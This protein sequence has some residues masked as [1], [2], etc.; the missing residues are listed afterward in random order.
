[1]YPSGLSALSVGRYTFGLP[2]MQRFIA[3]QME[4]G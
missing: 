4:S 2:L 1:M 3:L